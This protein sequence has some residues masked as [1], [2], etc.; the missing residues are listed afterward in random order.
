NAMQESTEQGCDQ[1]KLKLVLQADFYVGVWVFH[2]NKRP[3]IHYEF[4]DMVTGMDIVN[5]AVK[6]DTP[7]MNSAQQVM[8]HELSK[9]GVIEKR[10]RWFA[11]GYNTGDIRQGDTSNS[12]GLN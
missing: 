9:R 6:E 11:E 5:N 2:V 4:R 10:V 12:L 1:M 7:H 8:S 3:D